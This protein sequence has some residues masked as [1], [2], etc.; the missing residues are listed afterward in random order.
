MYPVLRMLVEQIHDDD[1]EDKT[2]DFF[3][4]N[5]SIYFPKNLTFHQSHQ[6]GVLVY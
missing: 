1:L 6:I 2:I 5:A 4:R 3:T